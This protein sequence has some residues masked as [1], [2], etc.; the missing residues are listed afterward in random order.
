MPGSIQEVCAF[1]PLFAM[2][3]LSDEPAHFERAHDAAYG[4][5]HRPWFETRLQAHFNGMKHD[6]EYSWHALRNAIFA[7][8]CRILA[9]EEGAS[10]SVAQNT[11]WPWFQ[12]A[13]SVHTEMLYGQT[14]VI[15]VQALAVMV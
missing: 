9:E 3:P 7:S 4:I 2:L 14:T 8:G 13:L 10:F 5:V 15:G 12:N 6:D 11:S 1:E